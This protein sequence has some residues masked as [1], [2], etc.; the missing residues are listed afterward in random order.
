MVKCVSNWVCSGEK[1]LL[2]AP[3]PASER[4]REH[5]GSAK[6]KG[7]LKILGCH[8]AKIALIGWGSFF[9]EFYEYNTHNHKFLRLMCFASD[10]RKL[11]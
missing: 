4:E 7:N 10:M 5:A 2:F 1:G 6:N 11:V 8:W 9:G 3:V